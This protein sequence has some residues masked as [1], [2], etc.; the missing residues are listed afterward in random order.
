LTVDGESLTHEAETKLNS[1]RLLKGGSEGIAYFI[2]RACREIEHWMIHLAN[3]DLAYLQKTASM[4]KILHN[5]VRA[6]PASA[7]AVIKFTPEINLE[8][9]PAS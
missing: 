7:L 8:V 4:A 1:V 2:E 6:F 3:R 5:S 9:E